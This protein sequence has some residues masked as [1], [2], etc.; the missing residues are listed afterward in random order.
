MIKVLAIKDGNC[1]TVFITE[2]AEIFYNAA[3]FMK[4]ALLEPHGAK[5]EIRFIVKAHQPVNFQHLTKLEWGNLFDSIYLTIN[6][7]ILG[8][9]TKNDVFIQNFKPLWE[10]G[11]KDFYV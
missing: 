4:R 5:Y 2:E 10:A 3:D 7:Q 9:D 6:H 8:L 11:D 1:E